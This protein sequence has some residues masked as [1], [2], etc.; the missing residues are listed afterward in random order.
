M[1][2]QLLRLIRDY[3]K[4]YDGLKNGTP[5]CKIDG[6]RAEMRKVV[7]RFKEPETDYSV[8]TP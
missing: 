7:E 4:A 5:V 1:E 2:R 3:L 8:T 6:L